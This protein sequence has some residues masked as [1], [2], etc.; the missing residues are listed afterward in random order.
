MIIVTS[1]QINHHFASAYS[2]GTTRLS[3]TRST[4]LEPSI[5]VPKIIIRSF[6]LTPNYVSITPKLKMLALEYDVLLA[7]LVHLEQ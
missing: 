4:E 6:V 1:T 7:S 5:Y 2:L 3:F